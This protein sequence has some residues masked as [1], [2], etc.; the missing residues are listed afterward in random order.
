MRVTLPAGALIAALIAPPAVAQTISRFEGRLV[1][2]ATGEP[3]AGATVSIVGMTGTVRSDQDGRFSWSPTPAVPFQLIVILPGG[4]VARP[5]TIDA[6]AEGITPVEIGGLT[7]EAVSVI[8]VAPS[9]EATPGS[10]TTVLSASQI[11]VRN[12]ENLMQALETVPGINQVSEGH[13]S[14]PAVRGLARPPCCRRFHPRLRP[15]APGQR[16][17]RR[18]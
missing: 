16:P 18:R 1:Q 9:I 13:A 11:S 17:S 5:V 14:V 15:S 3:V 10:A 4:Q 7:D 8:G 12:P 6:L 2:Q